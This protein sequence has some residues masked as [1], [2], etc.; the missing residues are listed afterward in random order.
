VLL[1]RTSVSGRNKAYAF[2]GV[3]QQLVRG[4][5]S[6][7]PALPHSRSINAMGSA[8]GRSTIV[9]RR[10]KQSDQFNKLLRGRYLAA[11]THERR[12]A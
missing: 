11:A 4:E 1:E 10:T 12:K 3:T 8:A 5:V 9:S 7:A 2:S 6:G